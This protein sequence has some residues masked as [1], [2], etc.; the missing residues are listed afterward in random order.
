M[1]NPKAMCEICG[2]LPWRVVVDGNTDK[3]HVRLCHGCKRED[4][5]LEAHARSSPPPG[6]ITDDCDGE[7]YCAECRRHVGLT[8]HYH[9]PNC[10]EVCSMMGHVDLE[11][12][13]YSCQ[14]RQKAA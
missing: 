12:N 8:S 5:V 3:E 11:K 1:P 7:G 14:R 2:A 4:E 10:G 13:D 9:C 6:Q